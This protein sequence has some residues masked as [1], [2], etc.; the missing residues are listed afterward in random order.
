[1]RPTPALLTLAAFVVA[2]LLS[3]GMAVVVSDALQARSARHVTRALLAS[4]LKWA[5]AQADG[6]IVT[7]TGTAPTEAARFRAT[8][9]AGR[10]VGASRV[11]DAMEVTP[12]QALTAPRFSLELLRNDD[13]VSMIGLV[14]EN[15]NTE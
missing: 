2:A 3:W 6:L 10:V 13:G 7:L 9:V 15:W 12:A 4:D 5:S 8:T 1:M 14:P 11:I